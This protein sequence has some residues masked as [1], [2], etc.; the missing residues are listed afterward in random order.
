MPKNDQQADEM[1]EYFERAQKYLSLEKIDLEGLRQVVEEAARIELDPKSYA[2]MI[3]GRMWNAVASNLVIKEVLFEGQEDI[4]KMFDVADIFVK[5]AILCYERFITTHIDSAEV[6]RVLGDAYLPQDLEK[7]LTEYEIALMYDRNNPDYKKTVDYIRN[8][9][10]MGETARNNRSIWNYLT[11]DCCII[12]VSKIAALDDEWYNKGFSLFEQGKY[13][14]ILKFFNKSL[15]ISS[16]DATTWDLKG[17]SLGCLCRMEDAAGCFEEALSRTKDLGMLMLFHQH[18]GHLI[19]F[20]TS[21]EPKNT[22]T[23]ED[24]AYG[25][26]NKAY[27]HIKKAIEIF[28]GFSR[29]KMEKWF[30][31][32]EKLEE[33]RKLASRLIIT[34]KTDFYRKE[35]AKKKKEV[36]EDC[37]IA[38][39]VYGTPCV[40]ELQILREFRDDHLTKNAFGRLFVS[41]YYQVSPAIAAFIEKHELTKSFM[42]TILI[43]PIVV[44][45]KNLGFV[46]NGQY[47]NKR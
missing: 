16:R 40:L 27:K 36:K 18:L 47:E 38:T 4:T 44:I 29:K 6:H 14:E 26:L 37:F 22:P 24:L 28:D 12:H 45:I 2:N 20:K 35:Y 21:G 13:E 42:R 19:L 30:W 41:F 10:E 34:A 15:K 3:L 7:A 43:K 32:Y 33:E 46:K 31:L 9:I 11:A 17:C 5:K 23:K 1:I 39:A 25:E 8:L